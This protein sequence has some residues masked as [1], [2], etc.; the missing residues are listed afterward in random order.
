MKAL[1]VRVLIEAW[2]SML[3]ARWNFLFRQNG[4]GQPDNQID[5]SFSFFEE[6]SA[7]GKRGIDDQFPV[8]CITVLEF[9][10]DWK[11]IGRDRIAKITDHSWRD[12][13]DGDLETIRKHNSIIDFNARRF[14]IHLRSGLG[15]YQPNGDRRDVHANSRLFLDGTLG[16]LLFGADFFRADF[17]GLGLDDR[18]F[19][20]GH[21][22]S[23]VCFPMGAFAR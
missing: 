19:F 23:S 20:L 15:A 4:N 21:E 22:R 8:L 6:P 10:I 9:K 7:F 17:L 13:C 12:G 2:G 18:Y 5:K 1:A 14:G 3:I 16:A 11:S